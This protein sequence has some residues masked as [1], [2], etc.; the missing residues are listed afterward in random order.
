MSF[1]GPRPE[2]P[3]FVKQLTREIPYYDHRHALKPGLT[4]W[5]QL[6]HHYAASTDDAKRKLEYDLYYLTHCGFFLDFLI[7]LQTVRVVIWPNGVR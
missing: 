3:Y 2:R 1:V 4:G 7:I 6:C 5:A